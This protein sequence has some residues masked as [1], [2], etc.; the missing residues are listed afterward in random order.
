MK[1]Y[2]EQNYHAALFGGEPLLNWDLIEYI[3]PI[4]KS[5]PRCTQI[6]V[7]T[8]GLVLQK[9]GKL[10]WL[11]RNNIGIS[12]SFDGLWNI[13]NRPLTGGNSSLDVYMDKDKPLYKYLTSGRSCKVMV[14]PSSAATMVENYKW[15]VETLGVASP[16]YSLVRD[17]NWTDD[18]IYRFKIEVKKL[19][20]QNI[21][22]LANLMVNV[23]LVALLVV[24]VPDLCL[25]VKCILVRDLVLMIK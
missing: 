9:E 19:A 5:D 20:D 1:M 23:L 12:L 17:Q 21:E 15:F 13:E 16:D 4:L 7:M 8:N 14:A 2:K 10:D 24:M 6:V 25:M 22:Y 11:M 18:D 3:V